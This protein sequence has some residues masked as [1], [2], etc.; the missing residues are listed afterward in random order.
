V[1]TPIDTATNKVAATIKVGF[2]PW[3]IAIAR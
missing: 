3:A 2:Y 1:V